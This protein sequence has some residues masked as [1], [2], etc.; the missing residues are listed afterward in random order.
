[1]R[2]EREAFETKIESVYLVTQDF[3]L[4]LKFIHSERL[5]GFFFTSIRRRHRW[6]CENGPRNRATVVRRQKTMKRANQITNGFAQQQ[7]RRNS[8]AF[9]HAADKKCMG[10]VNF[11]AASFA[12]SSNLRQCN[13]YRATHSR[14]SQFTETKR[15]ENRNRSNLM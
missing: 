15:A 12:I 1:M 7:T 11:Y 13:E 8:A 6:C 9:V 14:E 5:V 4:H 2:D 3:C 10:I